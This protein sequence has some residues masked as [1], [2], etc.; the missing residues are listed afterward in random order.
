MCA[1]FLGRI[2]IKGEQS[3]KILKKTKN[4]PHRE[5][6]TGM[7]IYTREMGQRAGKDNM[8][9][10]TE[11]RVVKK[12]GGRGGKCLLV[13]SPSIPVKPSD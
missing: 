5:A 4:N 13:V 2:P 1:L 6:H 7:Q 9:T 12:K 11:P 8:K 10:G 3:V